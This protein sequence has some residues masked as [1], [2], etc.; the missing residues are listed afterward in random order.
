MFGV[1]LSREVRGTYAAFLERIRPLDAWK[2]ALDVPSGVDATTG[3]ILGDAFRADLTVTYACRKA[4]LCLYPGR[5]YAGHIEVA[6]VGIVPEKNPAM[7]HLEDTDLAYIP[8]RS[9]DGNKGTFGKVLVVAGS[10]GMSGAAFFSAAGAFAAG[11]GMVRIQT[12]KDN[13]T[14]LAGLLPEAILSTGELESDYEKAISWCDVLVIGPGIG[15][16]IKA[17]LKA[18]WFL[19]KAASSGRRVVLDADGLN[20]LAENPQWKEYLTERVILTPHIGEMSRLMQKSAEEIKQ[21]PAAAARDYAAQTGAV[22]V[23]KDAC[24]VVASPRG[25]IYYNLSGNS[26]MATAGSGDVLSGVLGALQG[27]FEKSNMQIDTALAAAIGVYWH[28]KSGEL[29]RERIGEH[30]VK[31]RDLIDALPQVLRARSIKGEQEQ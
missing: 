7:R 21:N 4:G 23:L 15:T 19:W 22:C 17:A 9:A 26:S 24:T 28:G 30:G 27:L 12:V 16:S 1:G 13:K 11:A 6:D 8:P 14:A 5:S 29:A 31:A 3:Q 20:L 2:V 18:G 10:E 25:E